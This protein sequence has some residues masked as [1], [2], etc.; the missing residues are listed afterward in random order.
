MPVSDAIRDREN[1]D[2]GYHEGLRGYG[3]GFEEIKKGRPISI[4]YDIGWRLGWM[5][6]QIAA[7]HNRL[8]PTIHSE[9]PED[10]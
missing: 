1:L 7:I 3:A 5:A 2:Q 9:R 8:Y 6:A 4:Y 10:V